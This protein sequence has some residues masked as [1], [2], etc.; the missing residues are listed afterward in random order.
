MPTIKKYQEKDRNAEYA[1]KFYLNKGYTPEQSSAIVG[2]LLKES[3]LKTTAEGDVGY[4]GGSSFGVAQWRGERLDKLKSK[5]G[6]DWNKLENQLEFVH[7]ELNN[8]EKS[9]GDALKKSKSVWEAGRV[10]TNSYERPKLKFDQDKTRQTHVVDAYRNYAKLQLTEEDKNAFKSTFA[11]DVA[12]YMNQ[13]TTNDVTDFETTKIISNFASVPDVKTPQKETE[14]KDALTELKEKEFVKEYKSFF[15]EQ[16][17][18]IQQEQP[19]QPIQETDL[20]GIYNEVSNFIDQPLAQQGGKIPVSPYGMYKFP[21]QPVIVPTNG[22][23]TMK[24]IPHKIKAI[25]IETGETKI[26]NPSKEYFFKNT[27][28]I[29]EIPY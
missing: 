10:F 29:L 5:Y 9:A 17:A 19:Y 3:G 12:P 26:L 6:K 27:E 22:A 8:T 24:N 20:T 4:K 23:I 15:A 16:R 28:N 2:N 18:P 25:S 11:K 14:T 1:Y 13:A 7:W 21:N